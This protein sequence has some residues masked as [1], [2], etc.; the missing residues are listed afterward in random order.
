MPTAY[1]T[2]SDPSVPVPVDRPARPAFA[3]LPHYG[4]SD[5]RADLRRELLAL[6]FDAFARCV[7]R[8]L[9]K[10]GYRDV[11]PVSGRNHFAGRNTRG[12][13]DLAAYLPAGPHRRFVAVSLKQ[14][15][16]EP[17]YRRAVDELRGLCLRT[18]AAEGL[19]VTTS[20]LSGAVEK[21][22]VQNAPVA[23]VRFF[24]GET[25]LDLLILHRLGVTGSDHTLSLN[26]A[27]FADLV[28]GAAGNAR[29]QHAGKR[30]KQAILSAAGKAGVPPAPP[31]TGPGA[32][33]PEPRF[34]VTVSVT[35]VGV[36][37]TAHAG[38]E[39]R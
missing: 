37:G 4:P 32:G 13:C 7:A 35:P 38:K 31:V 26:R 25:L 8:L 33:E 18:G 19:I 6:P 16:K 34:T 10:A 20:S 15:D 3:P 21:E 27:F 24:D 11:S 12:G 5:L 30:Q 23:P 17:V 1:A 36:R 14:Y 28:R 2:K 9:E 39:E 22:R 29:A